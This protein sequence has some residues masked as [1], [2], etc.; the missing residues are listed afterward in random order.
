[1]ER[2]TELNLATNEL[3]ELD[4]DNEPEEIE[5]APQ[6]KQEPSPINTSEGEQ[7]L[8]ENAQ[9]GMKI[10]LGSAKSTMEDLC[11]VAYWIKLNFFNGSKNDKS[12]YCG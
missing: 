5:D 4:I 9:T 6:P 10:L 1:M 8:I 11:N 2:K 3:N 12:S 7:L